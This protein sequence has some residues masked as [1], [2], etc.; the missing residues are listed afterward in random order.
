MFN[1]FHGFTGEEP[2]VQQANWEGWTPPWMEGE[3]RGPHSS[4]RARAV[5][6]GHD[7]DDPRGQRGIQGE[8]GPDAVQPARD[9]PGRG[10]LVR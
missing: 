1:N 10:A 5:D 7:P 2:E 6:A 3:G 8:H 9:G 4:S